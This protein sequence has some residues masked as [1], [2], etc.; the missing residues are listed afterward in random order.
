MGARILTLFGEEYA[1]EPVVNVGKSKAKQKKTSS[2]EPDAIEDSKVNKPIIDQSDIL[3]GWEPEKQYY[4]IGEV[5]GL[6]KVNT[7]HIRFWT[8]EF[9]LKVRTTKK[10]DRLY[11]PS[12]IQEIGTIYH[13]VKQKG[14][15]LSGAKLKLKERKKKATESINLKQSLLKLRDQLTTIRNQLG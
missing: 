3:S 14:Y 8:K 15:T 1:P 6:F 11:T 2:T 10:G 12:Q 4:T 9:A 13:L 7:S 5:S